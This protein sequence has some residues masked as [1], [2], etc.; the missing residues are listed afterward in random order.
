M[1]TGTGLSLAMTAATD[2]RSCPLEITSFLW[3]LSGTSWWV[4]GGCLGSMSYLFIPYPTFMVHNSYVIITK[5]WQ[6][7]LLFIS[8]WFSS[9]FNSKVKET[10]TIYNQRFGGRWCSCHVFVVAVYK[11]VLSKDHVRDCVATHLS[12]DVSQYF[13]LFQGTL[14]GDKNEILFTEF[15]INYNNESAV[16]KKGTT[17]IWEKVRCSRRVLN[18]F[19]YSVGYLLNS[20]DRNKV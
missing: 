8:C 14:A 4:L 9:S 18:L 2:W 5:K 3:G 20:K 16:H 6:S 10:A 7:G 15:G 19:P 13:C 1:C 17:L 12:L 11:T